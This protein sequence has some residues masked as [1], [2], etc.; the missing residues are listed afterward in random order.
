MLY[1]F[2]FPETMRF[3][4]LL[5][6]TLALVSGCADTID[7]CAYYKDAGYCTDF[8]DQL[9]EMCPKTCGFCS[10][11]GGGG[12]SGSGGDPGTA[13]DPRPGGLYGAISLSPMHTSES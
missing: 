2:I 13:T 7:D 8:K 12:D 4:V 5:A 10:G 11:G 1:A 9:L 3:L 6:A